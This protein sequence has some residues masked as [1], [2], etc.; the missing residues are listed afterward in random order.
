M[1]CA[2]GDI[3]GLAVTTLV[4][5]IG[6][7]GVYEVAETTVFGTLGLPIILEDAYASWILAFPETWN[8]VAGFGT[9]CINGYNGAQPI[10]GPTTPG[11]AAGYNVGYPVGAATKVLAETVFKK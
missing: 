3:G 11:F 8:T 7:M 1:A 10:S 2:V 6:T 5:A 4:P 9:G